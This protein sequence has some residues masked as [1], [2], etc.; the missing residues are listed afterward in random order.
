MSLEDKAR[1]WASEYWDAEAESA[2]EADAQNLARAAGLNGYLIGYKQ[3]LADMM[4]KA[5][6]S[7]LDFHVSYSGGMDMP[8]GSRAAFI[9]GETEPKKVI[10][11]QT[12]EKIA[13]DLKK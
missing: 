7:P 6:E 13:E 1:C 5:S 9:R 8:D 12:L 11:L 3:A 4:E 2:A 10:F